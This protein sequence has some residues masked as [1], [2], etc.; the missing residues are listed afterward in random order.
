MPRLPSRPR[1]LETCDALTAH[2]TIEL[3]IKHKISIP[4]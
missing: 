1:S 2:D 4:V 3:C